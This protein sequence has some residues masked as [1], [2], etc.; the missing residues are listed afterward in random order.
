MEAPRIMPQFSIRTLLELTAVVLAF[1]YSRS[2]EMPAPERFRL[3]T[4]GDSKGNV[5]L[6]EPQTGACWE[7]YGSGEWITFAAPI[8]PSAQVH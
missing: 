5:L 7:R 3:I 2:D 4:I 1:L 6:F 8:P